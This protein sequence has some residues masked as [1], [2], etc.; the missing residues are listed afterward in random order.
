MF[1]TII[2]EYGTLPNKKQKIK[3]FLL[4]PHNGEWFEYI[5]KYYFQGKKLIQWLESPLKLKGHGFE[6]FPELSFSS[7][8]KMDENK[9]LK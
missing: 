7:M 4:H 1:D 8:N 9:F 2:V 3:L 6:P 5:F